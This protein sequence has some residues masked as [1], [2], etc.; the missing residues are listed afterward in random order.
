[1][2]L[3]I[4]TNILM[5][6]YLIVARPYLNKINFFFTIIFILTAITLEAF[7]IHFY[8]TDSITFASEKTNTA[9]PL[10]LTICSI[11]ILLL[12]WSLWRV[13]WEV[14]FLVRNFK[15]TLLYL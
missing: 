6:G 2:A 9:Y 3:L 4:S 5:F 10:V 14:S 11:L 12:I 15:K 8:Q 7:F 1:M 13:V